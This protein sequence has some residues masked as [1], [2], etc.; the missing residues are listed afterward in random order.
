MTF[1]TKIRLGQEG[2]AFSSIAAA[3]AVNKAVTIAMDGYAAAIF[4]FKG[5]VHAGFNL[6]F[7]ASPNSTDG[8]DG[9]WFPIPGVNVN[10]VSM[11]LALNTGVLPTNGVTTWA[12]NTTG[13][14]WARARVTAATSGT[15]DVAAVSTAEGLVRAIASAGG[16]SGGAVT[17]TSGNITV[18]GTVAVSSVAGTVTVGGTV[19]LSGTSPV[20]GSV[21]VNGGGATSIAKL[22]DAASADGDMGVSILGVRQP[23]VPVDSTSAA[24]DY[25]ALLVDREGKL[26]ISGNGGPAQ[27]EF[28]FVGLTGT[29]STQ[30]LAAGAAGVRHYITDIVIENASTAN[31]VTIRDGAT[32]IMTV[33]VPANDTRSLSFHTPLR[34]GAAAILNAQALA[35]TAINVWT[36]GY[37]GI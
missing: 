14:A 1:V 36:T 31:R 16:G 17:V 5:A 33:S 25:S 10:V 29:S 23:A 6:V 21:A 8:V 34:G 2:G 32:A 35:S 4:Y 20:S 15:L 3:T 26:I 37:A 27:T 28:G 13:C 22:E 24:G 30:I 7:E 19:A 18:A 11:A 12:V 9:D